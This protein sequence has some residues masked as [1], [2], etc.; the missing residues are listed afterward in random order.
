[1]SLHALKMKWTLFQLPAAVILLIA[2]VSAQGVG[3]GTELVYLLDGEARSD[4]FGY[5]VASAGDVDGDGMDDLIVG[6]PFAH[7]GDLPGTGLAEV[8]SGIDGS[9]L[10]QWQGE[11]ESDWFGF[12]VSGAGDVNG[13]GYDDLVVGAH[14]TDIGGLVD[15]GSVFVYS[16]VDGALLYRMD[17]EASGDWFGYSVSA[18]GDVDGDG[19]YDLI[20]GAHLTDRSGRMDSG[21]AYVF[22]GVDG[23]LLHRRDGTAAGDWFGFSVSGAGDVNADGLDDLIV[24]AKLASPGGL[25]T[26]GS[27]AVLSGADG[28]L[29]HQWNGI[30]PDDRLGASVS[31]AGDVDGDGFAD[32]IV[33]AIGTDPGGM[34][35]A[36]SAYVF[37]GADGS[38][39]HQ[40]DGAAEFDSFGYSVSGAGDIDGD[41]FDDLTVGA[42]FVDYGTLVDAGSAFVF[43]GADGSLQYQWTG[44]TSRD[45]LGASVAGAGNINGDGFD[46]LIVGAWSARVGDPSDAG[47]AR[48]YSGVDGVLIHQWNG[49]AQATWFG[50]AVANAGDVNGDGTNDLIVGAP[51]MDS[52][53]TDSG[54]L[55][56]YSGVDGSLIRFIQGAYY[57]DYLGWSVSGAGDVNGDGFDDVI[58]GTYGSSSQGIIGAGSAFVYSGS[59]GSL[60]HQWY[61]TE[62]Y[63]LFGYSVSGAG[64]VNL[65]G[66][67]DVIVGASG[68]DFNYSRVGEAFVFSGFDGSEIHH[69]LGG[70]DR[71]SFGVSV[72]GVG[73]VN[74]D[75]YPD[76]IVGA[77]WTDPNGL[78]AAGSAYVYSGLDGSLLY[79]WN[80]KSKSDRFGRS[81]AGAGDVN[82]DG[83]PDLIV[84]AFKVDVVPRYSVGAAYVYS[85]VDGS[86]LHRWEG[87]DKISYF[88]YSVSGAGD[89]NGD[90]FDDLMV[91]SNTEFGGYSGFCFVYSGAD[92]ALLRQLDASG[93][94]EFSGV[95]SAGLGDVNGDGFDDVIIG[96]QWP[97]RESAG[98]A[99][100]YSFNPYLR[101]N[102]SV[103]SASAGGVINLELSFPAAAA[104]DEY[105]VLVSSTGTGPIHFGVDIPLTQDTLL[106]NTYF[107]NYHGQPHHNLHGN[108]DASGKASG[109][110]TLPAGIPSTLVGK[111]YYIA[112]IANQPGQLPEFS[113][114]AIAITI[115]P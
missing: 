15:V 100:V 93:Q 26:A 68:N 19:F 50:H 110:L 11:A 64:D 54:G 101:S 107:G 60:L 77:P 3:G 52:W 114:A 71:D 78:H 111:S 31:N 109:S 33:G 51:A 49:G 14:L 6:T 1:M 97:S 2:S 65:D 20:A 66:Y 59:D 84:G 24:G 83:V 34:S 47:L 70:I 27:A 105:K 8:Y 67:D 98:L 91:C 81:V 95:T 30:A 21:S 85:G 63:K 45:F 62:A 55:F 113:S 44:S 99:Y 75:G 53:A 35:D 106:I 58:A 9:L 80:G 104:F 79:Q 94:S 57:S 69:W 82:G 42:P 41:G 10:Y 4:F 73:D 61:G 102:A 115:T 40:W 72:D 108:L 28:S 25:Q 17:G 87:G 39:I 103:I 7:T 43:S 92:G 48:V 46:D 86:L 96:N 16:G 36:G 22:S 32:L 88:G 38:L 18:A 56:I 90:G 29:I 13:D 37:A 89:V 5:S 74:S 112:A 12:S 76:L 23:S